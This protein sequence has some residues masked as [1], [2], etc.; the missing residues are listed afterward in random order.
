[1]AS[2]SDPR[3]A[4]CAKIFVISAPSGAGKTTLCKRLLDEGLRL[5]DSISMTT[6]PPRPGE[7][8]GVDYKFTTRGRF[9][10]MVR[11]GG[12]L[13]YEENFGFLYGTPKKFVDENLACGESVLLSIDVKGAMKVRRAYGKNAV[14][15]FI[16]PPSVKALKRRLVGRMSDSQ[17]SIMTRLAVARKEMSYKTKYDYTIVNDKLD[18]AYRK[19]KEIVKTESGRGK[20]LC[21]TPSV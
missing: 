15:I 8:N 3:C 19:L 2:R 14:L 12:F 17:D 9:L 16:L 13:E 20:L 4:P 10:E 6:R 18:R 5:A 1:M 11:K 21:R 7:R